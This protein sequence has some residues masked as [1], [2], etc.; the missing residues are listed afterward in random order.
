MVDLTYL[1]ELTGPQKG[2]E[3]SEGGGGCDFMFI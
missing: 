3:I 1:T 2:S